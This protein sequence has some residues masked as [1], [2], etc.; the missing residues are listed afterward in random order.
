MLFR[1]MIRHTRWLVVTGVQTC[2]LPIYRRRLAGFVVERYTVDP[3]CEGRL[4]FLI[5]RHEQRETGLHLSHRY[6]RNVVSFDHARDATT[7]KP[8][9]A[10]TH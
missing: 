6:V 3:D 10:S 1:S 2:A 9:Q 8:Y 7:T 4:T 5:G